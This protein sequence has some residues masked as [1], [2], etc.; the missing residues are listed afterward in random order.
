M[1]IDFDDDD[2]DDFDDDPHANA[3]EAPTA[4]DGQPEELASI[5]K[6]LKRAGARVMQVM[7]V[8]KPKPKPRSGLSDTIVDVTMHSPARVPQI[9]RKE[10]LRRLRKAEIQH[11]QQK[12][13]APLASHIALQEGTDCYCMSITLSLGA[14]DLAG[15]A[16]S[17]DGD[18]VA[19]NWMAMAL[20]MGDDLPPSSTTTTNARLRA[21]YGP[22]VNAL[23][24]R[25]KHTIF[26]LL[27]HENLGLN[28]VEA[29]IALGSAKGE[30]EALFADGDTHPDDDKA[31]VEAA[32]QGY[33]TDAPAPDDASMLG[34][35]ATMTITI[36]IDPLTSRMLRVRFQE[37][38]RLKTL[39]DVDGSFE[40][41]ATGTVPGSGHN[42]DPIPY[43]CEDLLWGQ[44]ISEMLWLAGAEMRPD[45]KR[46]DAVAFRQC[47]CDAETL[48]PPNAPPHFATT[49]MSDRET[50]QHFVQ[51]RVA[52]APMVL[53]PC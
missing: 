20:R 47:L 38:D 41:D 13:L 31:S 28:E 25:L 15:E 23:V 8:P 34:N 9:D 53:A 52:V 2:D 7:D 11:K 29:D 44:T 37:F 26:A 24:A 46:R 30:V 45:L 35:H 51:W 43:G 48:K 40:V 10:T 22:M 27:S 49:A 4:D 17:H 6:M 14:Y 32:K 16:V 36:R 33:Q 3:L 5:L 12:T 42:D 1:L 21:M 39:A 19:P 50:N 18:S